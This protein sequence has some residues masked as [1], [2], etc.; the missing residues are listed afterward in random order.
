MDKQT[1]ETIVD[2]C[3]AIKFTCSQLDKLAN[4]FEQSDNEKAG[5][6]IRLRSNTIQDNSEIVLDVIQRYFHKEAHDG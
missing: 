6:L 4:A 1:F 3:L 5:K 2:A